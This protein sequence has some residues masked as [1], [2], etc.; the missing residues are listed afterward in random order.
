MLR[1]LLGVA[2]LIAALSV[3]YY[4]AIALPQHNRDLLEFEKEKYKAQQL[5]EAANEKELKEEQSVRGRKLQMCIDRANLQFDAGLKNNGTPS[6][7]GGYNVPIEVANSLQRSKEL[8]I[9][10]CHKLFGDK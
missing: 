6:R 10:E 1:G 2:M 8:S 3:S 9:A 5:K 7:T 4:F